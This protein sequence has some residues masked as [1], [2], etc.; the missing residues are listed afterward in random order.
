MPH[1]K[2]IKPKSVGSQPVGVFIRLF[3]TAPISAHCPRT[4]RWD[5]NRASAQ[6]GC[7]PKLSTGLPP[8]PPGHGHPRLQD[9]CRG[10]AA[11]PP[12]RH[13]SANTSAHTA[14]L[15]ILQQP[16][17]ATRLTQPSLHSQCSNSFRPRWLPTPPA[18]L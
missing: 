7:I 9:P 5:L 6:K 14:G 11:R 3:Q 8:R 1:N 12:R 2:I 15:N 17:S 13:S 16:R 4:L 18:R 10:A